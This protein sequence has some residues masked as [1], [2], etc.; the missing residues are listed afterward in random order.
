LVDKEKP[1][2]CVLCPTVLGMLCDTAQEHGLPYDPKLVRVLLPWRPPVKLHNIQGEISPPAEHQTP[3]LTY[4]AYGS[5]ITHGNNSMSANGMFAR[6]TAERLGVD[7]INLGFGGGAHCE[8]SLAHYIAERDDWDFATLEMGINMVGWLDVSDFAERVMEFIK[9]IVHAHTDKWIFCIDM[10][11]FYMDFDLN[12][13]KNHAYRAV[14]RETVAELASPKL[15][16][17]DGRDM[18]RD[19]R[20]LCADLVHPSPAGMEEI[21]QNLTARIQRV[22]GPVSILGRDRDN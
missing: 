19:T 5:S 15:V 4:L 9:P 2:S 10:F 6:R 12:S 18:L 7:L 13:E 14:V 17:I 16:H 8:A 20:G 22:M 11:P 3:S 1:E 21:S